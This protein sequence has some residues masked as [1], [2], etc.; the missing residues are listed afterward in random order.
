MNIVISFVAGYAVLSI[1]FDLKSVCLQLIAEEYN[2]V[3]MLI[4]SSPSAI[5]MPS[6]PE[7]RMA[8]HSVLQ[9]YK[10]PSIN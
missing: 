8:K 10:I 9:N 2:Q 7:E 6:P 4:R 1:P 5:S 3:M